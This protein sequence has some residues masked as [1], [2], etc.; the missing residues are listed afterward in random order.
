MYKIFSKLLF[1]QYSTQILFYDKINKKRGTH[2]AMD[3]FQLFD[4][5]SWKNILTIEEM[6]K[7]CVGY[8][9]SL[10]LGVLVSTI[11]NI[12]KFVNIH[13]KNIVL[14]SLRDEYMYQAIFDFL[15]NFFASF[16]SLFS[17]WGGITFV[18]GCGNLFITYSRYSL[19]ILLTFV[20]IIVIIYVFLYKHYDKKYLKV[21]KITFVNIF[22]SIIFSYFLPSFLK[23]QYA[24]LLFYIVLFAS[25]L[26]LLWFLWKAYNK[27][28]INTPLKNAQ[29][30]CF[31]KSLLFIKVFLSIIY[32]LSFY[33]CIASN[34]IDFF[35]NMQTKYYM[36]WLIVCLF[37]N[38]VLRLFDKQANI[39]FTV[40]TKLKMV[41]TSEKIKCDA[42]KIKIKLKNK[43]ILY[44]NITEIDCIEYVITKKK[45]LK[46]HSFVTCL[47]E[48]ELLTYDTCKRRKNGWFY[49]YKYNSGKY[50]VTAFPSSKIEYLCIHRNTKKEE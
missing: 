36:A 5:E 8:A 38:I 42:D 28:I 24:K 6:Q 7:A 4:Y 13:T 23:F 49:F 11:P 22:F 50:F 26:E 10:L 45:L 35:V 17:I 25:S 43:D 29:I 32:L 27:L 39:V 1:L 40:K 16:G 14:P 19:L 3:L 18:I 21:V 37:E 33:I 34:K 9:V 2:K 46:H 30:N 31:T 12:A 15:H 47:F 20:C 41:K 44:L 48:N